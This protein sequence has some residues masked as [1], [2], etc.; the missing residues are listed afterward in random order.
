MEPAPG[1][2]PRFARYE[3][4]ALP[5]ML[6]WQDAHRIN[7]D[8]RKWLPRLDSNQIRPINSRVLYLLSYKAILVPP[9]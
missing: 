8:A 3:C 9:A 2:E 7:A 1:I 4:A 5:I 6:C